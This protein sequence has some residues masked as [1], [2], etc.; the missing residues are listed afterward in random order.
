MTNKNI[1]YLFYII[2]ENKNNF[3]L[4]QKKILKIILNYSIKKNI[5]KNF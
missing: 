2:I 4:F 3:K 1:F 5:K